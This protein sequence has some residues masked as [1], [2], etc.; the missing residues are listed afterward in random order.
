MNS[1]ARFII[2]EMMA[3]EVRVNKKIEDLAAFKNKA[4]GIVACVAFVSGGMG[5]VIL[6]LIAHI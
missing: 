5:A 4:L 6:K 3:M 1:D 2:K